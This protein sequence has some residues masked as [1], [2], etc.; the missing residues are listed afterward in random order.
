VLEVVAEDGVRDELHFDAKTGFLTF[1][2]GEKLGDYRQV[3][4]VKLPFLKIM[5]FGGIEIKIQLEQVS[6]NVSI[7]D[8]AFAEPRSCFTGQ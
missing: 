5:L 8:A 6:H 3:G 2:G 1:G 7:S 4:D